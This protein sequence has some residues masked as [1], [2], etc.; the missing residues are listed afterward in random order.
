MGSAVAGPGRRA[1]APGRWTPA[2]P[3]LIVAP[4]PL[5]SSP[6]EPVTGPC[7]LTGPPGGIPRGARTR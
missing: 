1:A 5:L 7:G 4:G 2:C 6:S 3:V